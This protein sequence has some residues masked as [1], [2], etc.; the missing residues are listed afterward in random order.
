[1][2]QEETAP[3]MPPAAP[4][5]I[6][7]EPAEEETDLNDLSSW[8]RSRGFEKHTEALMSIGVETAEDLSC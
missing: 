2:A 4:S 6:A 5:P 3:V 1:M 8:M 7:E